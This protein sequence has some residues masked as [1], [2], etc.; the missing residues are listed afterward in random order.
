MKI[1][2]V[3]LQNLLD[4]KEL[5]SINQSEDIELQKAY[6]DIEYINA[7]EFIQTYKALLENSEDAKF[8]L[9]FGCFLNI[10]ALGFVTYVQK[11]VHRFEQAVKLIQDYL[12]ESFPLVSLEINDNADQLQ[13]ILLSNIHDDDYLSLHI[14]DTVFSFIYREIKL[15]LP[16]GISFNAFLPYNDLSE[17]ERL[18]KIECNE[19]MRHLFQFSSNTLKLKINKK[20]PGQVE[21]L[22]PQYLKLLEEAKGAPQSFSRQV[23][24]ATLSMCS[25]EVPTLEQVRTQFPLSKRSFQ[26]KLAA[27]NCSFREIANDIKR[28]LYEYL[29]MGEVLKLH[30]IAYIL[31]YSD[32][33]ALLHAK[34]KWELSNHN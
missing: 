22:L 34:S 6:S 3:Q 28:K 15:L 4:H 1:S 2:T 10:K 13:L 20:A 21:Y 30:D 24:I 11:S 14:L 7:D 9:H 31:G 5:I 25:P 33:S 29:K 8:G 32:A 19:G 26:R 18:Y 12:D 27:D 23:K 17:Y 16:S